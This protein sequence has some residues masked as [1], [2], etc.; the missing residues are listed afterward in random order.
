M[1]V[2]TNKKV[3]STIIVIPK[4]IRCRVCAIDFRKIYADISTIRAVKNS[5]ALILRFDIK[6]PFFTL[7]VCNFLINLL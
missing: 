6:S 7:P 5:N 1:S 3:A 2:N 4:V